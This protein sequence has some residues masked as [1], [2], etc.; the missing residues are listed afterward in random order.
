MFG[1]CQEC[2]MQFN[3][4]TLREVEDGWTF[5]YYV[6]RHSEDPGFVGS[7]EVQQRGTVHCKL[8]ST[9]PQES[10]ECVIQHMRESARAWV[11]DRSRRDSFALA[12]PPK[13]TA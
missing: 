2:T 4:P 5:V 11:L 13:R 1:N 3:D 10:E 9:R 7:V 8:V 12:V 6:S